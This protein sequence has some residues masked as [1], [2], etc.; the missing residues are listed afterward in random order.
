MLEELIRQRDEAEA[1]YV[2]THSAEAWSEFLVLSI[3]V[4]EIEK[5][6]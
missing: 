6:D 2:Q 3:K 4:A 1:E 5:E